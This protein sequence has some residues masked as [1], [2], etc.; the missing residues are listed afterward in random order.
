MEEKIKASTFCHQSDDYCCHPVS[1][2]LGQCFNLGTG[3]IYAFF[4]DNSYLVPFFR[5]ISLS[6]KLLNQLR[7]I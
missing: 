6:D 3:P 5:N 7:S 1:Q 4:P 2:F